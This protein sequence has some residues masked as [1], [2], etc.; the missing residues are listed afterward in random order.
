MDDPG[1]IMAA[2]QRDVDAFCF[3]TQ[4]LRANPDF[5]RSA[6]RTTPEAIKYAADSLKADLPLVRRIVSDLGL[7][8][9][10]IRGYLEEDIWI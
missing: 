6:M 1:I 2:L 9:D 8:M 7:S 10:D 4:G 5:V 3:A